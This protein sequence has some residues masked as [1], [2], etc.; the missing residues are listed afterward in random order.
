MNDK[1]YVTIDNINTVYDGFF[2]ALYQLSV[3]HVGFHVVICLKNKSIA[4][5][6]SSSVIILAVLQ[7]S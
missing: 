7:K 5:N 2:A 6:N 3:I 1:N 4:K